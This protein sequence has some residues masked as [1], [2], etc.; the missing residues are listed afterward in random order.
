M[1]G[2][3]FDGGQVVVIPRKKR[4]RPRK[5]LVPVFFREWQSQFTVDR[6]IAD[7]RLRTLKAMRACIRKLRTVERD[8]LLCIAVV[9]E[10]RNGARPVAAL[11]AVR[12]SFKTS[13]ETV[14]AAYYAHRDQLVWVDD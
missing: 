4:G 2:V 9:E 12:E 3:R 5:S 7:E 10:I 8:E 13:Y 6:W 14:R 1:I 11:K